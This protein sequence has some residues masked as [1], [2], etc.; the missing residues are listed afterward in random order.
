MFT[1][2]YQI[3]QVKAKKLSEC[4][5]WVFS[6]QRLKKLTA[7]RPKALCKELQIVLQGDSFGNAREHLDLLVL[8][9][10]ILNKGSYNYG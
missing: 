8:N 3:S 5:F 7:Y 1:G 6:A 10:V 4:S 9:R 2:N